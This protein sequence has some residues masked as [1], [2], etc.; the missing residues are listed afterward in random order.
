MGRHGTIRDYETDELLGTIEFDDGA[1]GS[2]RGLLADRDG[3]GDE[4]GNVGKKFDMTVRA[5]RD[6]FYA[7]ASSL[8]KEKGI[9][10]C[11]AMALLADRA[12]YGPPARSIDTND[13]AV[14]KALAAEAKRRV[15]L[16]RV[17]SITRTGTER[18]AKSFSVALERVIGDFLSGQDVPGIEPKEES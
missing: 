11:E 6:A 9:D 10:T 15:E 16:S 1:G 8:A 7:E 4:G 2:R 18:E 17:D 12:A 3:G 14:R 5:D 13:P